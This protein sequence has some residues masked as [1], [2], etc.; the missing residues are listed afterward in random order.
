MKYISKKVQENIDK[1]VN[2]SNDK[3]DS[4]MTTT[5]PELF[6]QRNLTIYDSPMAQGFGIYPGW[7]GVLELLAQ[8]LDK[9]RIDTGIIVEFAQIKEK[10]ADACFYYDCVNSKN[11]DDNNYNYLKYFVRERVSHYEN[12]CGYIDSYSGKPIDREDRVISGAW[13]YTY[14]I[15][16]AKKLWSERCNEDEI[17]EVVE[18]LEAKIKDKKERKKIADCISWHKIEKKDLDKIKK[19][20]EKYLEK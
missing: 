11:I 15:D 7:F 6:R 14:G 13:M 2:M 4:Y 3:F 18:N 20:I 17:K 12:I 10:F 9:F 19:I 5:Y 16:S 8:E 1:F